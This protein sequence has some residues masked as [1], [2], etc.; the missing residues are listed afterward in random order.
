MN[1]VTILY[2]IAGLRV[3]IEFSLL[4]PDQPREEGYHQVGV[5]EGSVYE[6]QVTAN[7]NGEDLNRRC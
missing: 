5:E 4:I 7:N 1:F 2:S 3:A 6:G